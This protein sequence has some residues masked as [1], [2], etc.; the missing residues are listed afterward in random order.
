MSFA[1]L[2]NVS[3][4]EIVDTESL[5]DAIVNKSHLK[6]NNKTLKITEMG[7]DLYLCYLII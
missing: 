4:G 7:N 6:F 1:F 5:Y 3:R 2:I